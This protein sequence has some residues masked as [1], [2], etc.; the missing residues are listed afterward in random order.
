MEIILDEDPMGLET[1]AQ[2]VNDIDMEKELDAKPIDTP[3]VGKTLTQFFAMIAVAKQEKKKAIEVSEGVLKYLLK[4][5][6]DPNHPVM[7]FQDVFVFQEG[8]MDLLQ[9]KMNL[10]I[11]DILFG[12]ST[13]KNIAAITTGKAPE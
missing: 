1:E 5:K 11:N 9:S 12:H 8:K 6:F 3:A 7:V 4:E 2:G 13:V 10:K